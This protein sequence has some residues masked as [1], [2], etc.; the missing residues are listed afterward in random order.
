MC[1]VTYEILS[2][3]KKFP[4]LQALTQAAAFPGC[5]TS[6]MCLFP[7]LGLEMH[8]HIPGPGVCALGESLLLHLHPSLSLKLF[9]LVCI[10]YN[11]YTLETKQKSVLKTLHLF[12]GWI[13]PGLPI[14]QL[15]S[16]GLG[17]SWSPFLSWSWLQSVFPAPSTVICLRANTTAAWHSALCP[18]G[19]SAV[20]PLY[21]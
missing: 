20:H 5:P 21:C 3:S 9:N 11:T 17:P 12:C 19:K 4:N 2:V 13:K 6:S 8:P 1:Q 15:Q 14:R 16:R 10:T 18:M 7:V